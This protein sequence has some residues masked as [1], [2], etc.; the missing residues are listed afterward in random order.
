MT[1]NYHDAMAICRV[2]G[3]P[4]LFITF[5]CNPKWPDITEALRMEPGQRSCDRADIVSRVYHT[6]LQEFYN[7]V[8]DD[9]AFDVQVPFLLCISTFIVYPIY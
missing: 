6:K 7:D 2:Y 5:T 4:D 3:A 8:K 1:K 9:A